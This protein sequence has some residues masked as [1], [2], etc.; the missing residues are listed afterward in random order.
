MVRRSTDSAVAIARCPT[1]RLL[2]A[3]E[4]IRTTW[5]WSTASRRNAGH[6]SW[7]R[8]MPWSTC[9][10]GV[11]ARRWSCCWYRPCRCSTTA[12][13]S[14]TSGLDAKSTIAQ[15]FETIIDPDNA[16]P[17]RRSGDRPPPCKPVT[18]QDGSRSSPAARWNNRRRVRAAALR[19]RSCPDRPSVI[20]GLVDAEQCN[21]SASVPLLPAYYQTFMNLGAGRQ[22]E[23]EQSRPAADDRVI[24]R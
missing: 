21:Q 11:D 4:P 8:P 2:V 1:V 18:T 14:S 9:D 5:S 7:G 24:T 16:T 10:R 12:G 23:D 3:G 13:W 6:G 22:D 19:T 17:G 15:S 20:T